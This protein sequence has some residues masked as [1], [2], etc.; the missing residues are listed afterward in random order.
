MEISVMHSEKNKKLYIIDG[1]KFHFNKLL[2]NNI[3]R[4][5]CTK[6]MC[7]CYFKLNENSEIVFSDLNHNHAKDEVNILTRQKLSN[8]LKRKVLDDPCVKP[9]K[10]LHRELR[11]GDISSSLTTADTVRIRKNMQY[12]RSSV[13]PM[14]P[15]NLEELHLA[16]T[17]LNNNEQL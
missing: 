15:I 4:W 8:K 6:R 13:I 16:L 14:L 17:T 9:C 10:I 7:K 12:A 2:V 1:Y 5:S 11:K 3:Q